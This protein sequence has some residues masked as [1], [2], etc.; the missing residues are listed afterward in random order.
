MG[1]CLCTV[2]KDGE[3]MTRQEARTAMI[4]KQDVFNL[5]GMNFG[6]IKSIDF[7]NVWNCPDNIVL[8]REPDIKY[9]RLSL[10]TTVDNAR[11]AKIES[12]EN[13]I[14]N[15]DRKIHELIDRIIELQS[16]NNVTAT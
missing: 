2:R 4:Y 11:L 6:K 12:L 5:E 10:F 9:S 13:T 14:K 15:N 16:K 3:P 8:E 7:V 1:L